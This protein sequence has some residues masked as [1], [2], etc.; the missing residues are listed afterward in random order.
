M[1]KT[2]RL[3][4][5]SLSLIILF[6]SDVLIAQEGLLDGKVFIGQSKVKH[7][8]AV[9]EDE[10]RFLNG[11]FR[12]NNY[13]QKGFGDAAYIARAEDDKIYFETE[14]VSPKKGKINWR[15]IV[16]GDSIEV[17]YHLSKKGWLSNTEKDYVFEG[18]LKK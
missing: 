12:S 7:R 17:S 13:S 2:G 3:F 18:R 6:S 16:D 15:G 9:K 1:F 5:F 4:L 10:L 8:R 11:E 14:T